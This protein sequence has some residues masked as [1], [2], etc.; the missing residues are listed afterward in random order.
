MESLDFVEYMKVVG[1]GMVLWKMGVVV[2]LDY[3]IFVDDKS[4]IIKI[5]KSI[6]KII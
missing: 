1:M 2:K 3:V 6:F 5:I 4:F